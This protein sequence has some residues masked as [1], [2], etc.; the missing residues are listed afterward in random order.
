YYF[1]L[2]VTIDNAASGHARKAAEAV[3]QAAAQAADP[4]AFMQGV[5]RGYLLN[6]PGASTLGVIGSFVLQ[7]EVVR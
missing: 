7:D 4:Q 5:R 6:E 1:T 3:A 2:H